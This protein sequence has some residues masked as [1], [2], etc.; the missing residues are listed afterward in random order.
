MKKILAVAAIVVLS[1]G[2]LAQEHIGY[3][4]S[5]M[6]HGNGRGRMMQQFENLTPEQQT[7]FNKIHDE[8]MIRMRR[9][10]LDIREINLKIEKEMIGDKPNEK[11]I[12]KLIDEKARLQAEH[13]KS[14]LRFR[15]DMKEKFGIEMMGGMM[16]GSGGYN[17]GSRNG[18]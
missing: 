5:R 1:A 7:E 14:G 13:Q 10:M 3:N 18:N 15:L 6:S 17:M 11:N 8:H 12:N 4:N 2:A 16:G 9:S